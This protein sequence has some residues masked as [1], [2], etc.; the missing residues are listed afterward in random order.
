MALT[1]ND[2][3]DV[4]VDITLFYNPGGGTQQAA[5]VRAATTHWDGDWKAEYD[6][7]DYRGHTNDM[8]ENM[9]ADCISAILDS[10]PLALTDLRGFSGTVTLTYIKGTTKTEDRPLLLQL[11]HMNAEMLAG[12]YTADAIK[13]PLQFVAR[14]GAAAACDL[15]ITGA[16]G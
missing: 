14:R 12:N 4:S 15:C 1:W 11:S 8:C 6:G 2:I 9:A 13:T 3:V 7:S 10:Q 16:G 5:A